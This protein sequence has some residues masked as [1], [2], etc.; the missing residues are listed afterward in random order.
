MTRPEHNYLEGN[1]GPV[2]EE[3]T[4]VDLPV[5]GTIPAELDGRF[6]RNGPN[7]IDRADPE[8]YHWFTG[9]G[10]VHGVRLR[11]GRP[12]GTATAGCAAPRSRPRSASAA[13]PTPYGDGVPSFAANTNVVSIGGQ[14]YAIVEAGSP[15]VELTDE[16][17]TVGRSNFGGT[18]PARVH[19]PPQARPADGRA[20]RRRVLLGLWEH[21]RYMS[22]GA[23]G[24]V[25]KV[26]DVDMPGGPMVHD[27]RS[28]TR[29][30]VL[31][32]L[33][34]TFDVDAAMA[35]APLPYF[36]NAAYGARIGLLPRASA[37][38]DGP[39]CAG[40]TSTPATCTTRST[41]TTTAARS[42]STSVRHDTMFATN[43]QGPNEGPSTARALDDR[44]GRG[45]GPRVDA[46]R[47]PRGV[48]ARRTRRTRAGATA[49][50]TARPSAAWTRAAA[51]RIQ[52]RPGRGDL[53]R[54][55]L[56]AG[57]RDARAGVRGPGGR[58][59]RGRRLG[60]GLRLRRHDRPRR[61]RDPRRPGLRRRS[62]RHRP[63]P[64]PRPVRLPRQLGPHRLTL[65][66]GQSWFP[67]A[68]GGSPAT[69]V[70]CIARR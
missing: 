3:V 59:G 17:E 20:A 42:S 62:G 44:P 48:P 47:P 32:D 39:T 4:A 28:P 60:H 5:T 56:R 50:A 6:I 7:P 33:P 29:Y 1:F 64:G 66:V 21:I 15:P 63:S 55:R 31:F 40:S 38:T 18:L 30:A 49:T 27:W 24:K 19:R 61:R 58:D 35:G 53:G 12:S 52:A 14:T 11:G 13:P 65:T 36:W 46:R 23:D 51:R 70:R 45:Q 9:D 8:K 2:H 41:R 10:M 57:P 34:V 16:L 69:V 25:Q 68:I 43:R 22:V 37:A 54:A 26:V 67:G